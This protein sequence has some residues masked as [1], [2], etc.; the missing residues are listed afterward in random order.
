MWMKEAYAMRYSIEGS[1]GVV[2]R[3]LRKEV[4]PG[5][6]TTVAPCAILS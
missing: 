6:V 4:S 5:V 1:A 3:D 2:L